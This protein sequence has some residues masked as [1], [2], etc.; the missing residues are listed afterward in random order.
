MPP[1]L[2]GKPVL[3]SHVQE[4]ASAVLRAEFDGGPGGRRG[5]V[6]ENRGVPLSRPPRAL[7]PD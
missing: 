5:V 1:P 3:M 6:K 7:S 2:E 4:R